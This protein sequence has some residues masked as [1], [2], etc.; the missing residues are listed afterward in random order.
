MDQT[1]SRFPTPK[2]PKFFIDDYCDQ[3]GHNAWSRLDSDRWLC[4]HCGSESSGNPFEDIFF[5]P[6]D[7]G[8]RLLRRI[9]RKQARRGKKR[10]KTQR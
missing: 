6:N 8:G 9:R 1:F 7:A 5:A 4:Q 3:C 2:D 10:R